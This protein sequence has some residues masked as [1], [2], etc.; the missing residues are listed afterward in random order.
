MDA[1]VHLQ[2]ELKKRFAFKIVCTVHDSC[3]MYIHKEEVDEVNTLIKTCFEQDREEN[4]GI[5]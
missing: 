5:P 4:K 3:V 2:K 1:M